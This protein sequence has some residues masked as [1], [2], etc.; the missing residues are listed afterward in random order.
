[1]N[2][3]LYQEIEKEI[4]NLPPQD[5]SFE[6]LDEKKSREQRMRQ[7]VEHK[8]SALDPA[9][10]LRLQNEFFA[11]GPL[12]NLLEDES[13]T[14]L[15]VTAHNQI[16]YE[17]NGN[18]KAHDDQF[19]SK[20]T[21]DRFLDKVCQEA[22]VHFT[23]ENPMINGKWRD[24][25]LHI[26]SPEVTQGETSL[27]LRRHPKSPWTFE[28]L[29]AQNWC[30]PDQHRILKQVLD[31][32]SNFLVIGG[33][34]TGKTS[35]LNACLN[36]IPCQERMV[37]IE[38]TQELAI[39]NTFS[40]RLLT[41]NDTNGQLSSIDQ[42]ELVRQSL[43]MRPDRIVMGEIRGSEAKDLLMALSTGHA[44]S[45]GSLHAATA[46][47]ALIRLEM[48]IQMGAP[49]WSLHAIRNLIRFSLE[50]IVVLNKNPAGQRQ[51]QGLYQITS[52]EEMGILL[53]K[54]I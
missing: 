6:M 10:A 30:T 3:A 19:Y 48:L 1:M 51:L 15:I 16:C 23:L 47:Q 29:M 45:F 33:T 34:G 50:Y 27:S 40:T 4:Q 17:R 25:R 38:D 46:A 20:L 26:A 21:Y 24:F 7:V 44:G 35:F 53:E 5:I 37:I 54:I 42:G 22:E 32:R 18:L 14:E 49:N 39:P 11:E 43:R 36:Q 41:R 12:M 13:I 52:L 28:K 2:L 8:T 31:Q 9:G